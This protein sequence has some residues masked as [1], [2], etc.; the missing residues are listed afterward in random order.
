MSVCQV[1]PLERW[2]S[3]DSRPLAV[4]VAEPPDLAACHGLTFE[5][6]VDDLDRYRLAA[7]ELA[8]GQQAWLLKHEGDPN[9]GTVVRVDGRAD[10]E[11]AQRLLFG[12]LDLA[13]EDLLWSA[14]VLVDTAR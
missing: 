14:P 2:P 10:I 8:D 4:L 3:G 9:P 7:I 12:A 11:E 13:P 1:R 5:E 6:D